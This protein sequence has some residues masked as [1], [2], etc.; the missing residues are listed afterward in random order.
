M[1]DSKSKSISI[2][3]Y[4]QGYNQVVFT[5]NEDRAF[6]RADVDVASFRWDLKISNDKGAL[7]QVESLVDFVECFLNLSSGLHV[8]FEG[9]LRE[10]P[11]WNT[12]LA[13]IARS[14]VYVEELA[15]CA[16]PSTP[17]S[18]L[19]DQTQDLDIC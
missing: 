5:V 6:V 2:R 17:E 16:S 7:I 19:G 11:V 10:A 3:V 12:Y 13:K 15:I 14:T 1:Y 4:L 8:S 18:E 9:L